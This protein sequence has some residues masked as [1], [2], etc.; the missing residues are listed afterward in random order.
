MKVHQR[1]ADFGTNQVQSHRW[2]KIV[3]IPQ[4]DFEAFIARP[5]NVASN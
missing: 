2:Q 1:W 3:S 4:R 5:K